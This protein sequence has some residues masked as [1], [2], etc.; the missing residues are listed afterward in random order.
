[1]PCR[2]GIVIRRTRFIIRAPSKRRNFDRVGPRLSSADPSL[3][4]CIELFL[5]IFNMYLCKAD[6]I[7]YG[8]NGAG[9]AW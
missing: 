5:L 3:L 1:M 9:G 2:Y 4:S 7:Y 8:P 6:G